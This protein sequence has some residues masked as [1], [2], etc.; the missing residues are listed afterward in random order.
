[1]GN[2]PDTLPVLFVSGEKDPVG[3]NTKGVERVV[4]AFKKAGLNDVES[5]FYPEGRH[6]MLN[7]INKDEVYGKISDWI[8]DK[9]KEK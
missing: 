8:L 3:D 9:L 4:R 5:V 1:M 2:I 6:E 7:E